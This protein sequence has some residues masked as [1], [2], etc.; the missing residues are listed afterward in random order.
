VIFDRLV[1]D[2]ANVVN[3]PTDVGNGIYIGGGAGLIRVANTEILNAPGNGVHTVGGV[4]SN[5]FLS[6]TVH[7]NGAS[8]QLTHGFYLSSSNN[9]VDGCWV[10]NNAAYGVQV[11]GDTR[12]SDNVIRRNQ[13]FNNTRLGNGGGVAIASGDRNLAYNNIIW[14]HVAEA[15]SIAWGNPADSKVF[16]NTIYNQYGIYV[17]TDSARAVVQNNIVYGSAARIDNQ[18]WASVVSNNL[19]TNPMFADAANLN[20]RL[21]PGSP[22]INTGA[23]V[24]A[25]ADDFDTVPRPQQGSYDVGA[26][27][28]GYV[29]PPPAR[30][31][32]FH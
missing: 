6:L 28:Y 26:Y 15:I 4:Q 7:D 13:I 30:V 3:T 32:V 8:R 17:H 14:G 20:F 12:P 10:Y 31:R 25:V 23:S 2:A 11:F 22:A 18:G 21:R 9:L 29:L 27:E 1:L 16:N 19:L 24:A 5:Q